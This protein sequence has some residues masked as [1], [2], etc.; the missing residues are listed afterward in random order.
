M[1]V[2]ATLCLAW[3]AALASPAR[4]EELEEGLL[5]RRFQAEV[6]V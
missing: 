3:A 5:W 2:V 4:L 1:L 6:I